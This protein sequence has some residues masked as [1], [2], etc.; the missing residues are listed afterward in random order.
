LQPPELALV[1]K[2]FLCGDVMLGRG[3]DQALPEPC[4]PHLYEGYMDSAIGYLH[5][6]EEANGPI[7]LPLSFAYVWGA[8]LDELS[9]VN[10]HARV[11]NLETSITRS[12]VYEPKGINYRMSPENAGCLATASINCCVL[13]NNHVLD[14]GQGG[15]RDTL[16]TLH[17]LGIKTAG[18]GVDLAQASAPA[19]LGTNNEGRLLVWSYAIMTSG[20]PRYWAARSNIGG[21][22]LLPEHFEAAVIAVTR[23]VNEVRR[24]KDIVIVSIHWGS[25]WGYEIA[26]EERWFAHELI[27]RAGISILHGHSSHHAKAIEVY[28]NRLI[29]YGC[30]DFLNDYEG[31]RGYEG[32]RGYLAIMYLASVDPN[33]ANILA[34]DLVPLQIQRFQLVRASHKDIDWL[35]RTLDRET[36][37]F[38]AR[39]KPDG[40][41]ALSWPGATVGTHC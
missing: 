7:P 26:E 29:L 32:F 6:A 13:A 12:E 1:I 28:N 2:I 31:I 36:S 17:E 9:R 8:A 40:R 18:A 22:N 20:T 39:V 33:S 14:W 10:P 30:G 16:A 4:P 27:E 41:L 34:L 38:G 3:I 23:Q 11:I 5:L 35:Q 15:L 19:I 24:P 37:R 25:N 21:V